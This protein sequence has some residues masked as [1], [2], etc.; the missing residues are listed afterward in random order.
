MSNP[1]GLAASPSSSGATTAAPDL[2]GPERYDKDGVGMGRRKAT[3]GELPTETAD[4]SYSLTRPGKVEDE[5]LLKSVDVNDLV[6][7]QVR[8]S[9]EDM[10]RGWTP[11]DR[12]GMA[13]VTVA[14]GGLVVEVVGLLAH[15][16]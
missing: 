12:I 5:Q 7:H 15:G 3:T 13:C 11:R 16:P 8:V 10:E 9:D 2:M 14:G 6:D 1:E 4:N